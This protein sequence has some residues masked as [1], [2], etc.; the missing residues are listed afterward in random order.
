MGRK[1]SGKER[2]DRIEKKQKNGTIYVYDRVSVYDSEKRYYKSIKST[3]IG[4]KMPGSDEI[5]PTRP[6]AAAR[7]HPDTD[8]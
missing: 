5:V 8:A 1:A 7:A 2:H 6:K 4:K 3:L